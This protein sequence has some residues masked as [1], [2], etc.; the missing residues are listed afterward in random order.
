VLVRGALTLGIAVASAGPWSGPVA[1]QSDVTLEVGASQ[2]GP[3]LGVEGGDARFLI[4]GLRG[5][6]YTTG[7]S[8]VFG[9]I[10]F[11]Q[12]L[13]GA[14][15][16]S[17]LSGIVEGTLAQRLARSLTASLDVRLMGYG[18][19]DPFPYRAFA[20]EGGPTLRLRTTNVSFKVEGI[21]G[22][23]RS[24]IE[25]WRVPGG[26]TRLFED[27]LWR[28]G[29]TAELMVG[30]VTSSFGIVGGLHS[31]PAGDYGNVGGRL[32]L[33]GA[34]GLAEVR[35]DRW[36]TPT[37]VE[38]TGGLALVVPIGSG[39]SLRGFFGR[40]DPDPLTL[41]Q[42]GSGG[43]GV[44]LGRNLLRSLEGPVAAFAPYEIIEYRETTS[45]VRFSVE[46]PGDAVTVQLLGDFTL[47]EP[48][49][50]RRVGDRWIAEIDVGVGTYHFGF[51]IDDEWHV[52]DD[53]PDI[54]PDEW[55]RRSATLVIEGAS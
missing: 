40:S 6:H 43:G 8:G 47:W 20:A 54:V 26:R 15:G 33:A 44:L 23:G 28:A 9:S 24:R 30:P 49:P 3:P 46:A 42:P 38:T 1:A 25:L 31:T 2:I 51:L 48:I 4:G 41:A 21:G 32:V 14:T 34:W 29:G 53:A 13:E 10:L 11:G 19:Q 17:F 45:R 36:D 50:M 18:V 55:G 7:G 22:V 5:S 27:A 16:G 52:P 37:S 39:W 12:T 35:I